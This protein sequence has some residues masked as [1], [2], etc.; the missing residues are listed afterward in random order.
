MAGPQT[1]TQCLP[2]DQV[3]AAAGRE[4][5]HAAFSGAFRCWRP[6]TV[7]TQLHGSHR[8]HEAST[9]R[10]SSCARASLPSCGR[11]RPA[12]CHARD[13]LPSAMVLPACCILSPA[14]QVHASWHEPEAAHKL[15][16]KQLTGPMLTAGLETLSCPGCWCAG[17]C[18]P[19]KCDH[20]LDPSRK[21]H[22]DSRCAVQAPH[23]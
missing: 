20:L 22:A 23:R 12:A 21:H 16:S 17:A 6:S 15:V 13:L 3:L 19:A 5:R 1:G 9:P 10:C 8:H 7:P 2:A 4:L 14:A 18:R 11:G